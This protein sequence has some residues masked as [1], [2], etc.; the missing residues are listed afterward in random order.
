MSEKDPAY[1]TLLAPAQ[2]EYREKG[3]RFIGVAIPVA[4][5]EGIRLALEQIREDHHKARHVAYAW[6]LGFTGDAFRCNDDQEPS[7]SAG[8]PILGQI[9]SADLTQ[10]LVAVVRYFGGIKLGLS[11]L[12]HAYKAGAAVALEAAQ[13]VVKTLLD[14]YTLHISLERMG[15]AEH[16]LKSRGA[17]VLSREYG[18]DQLMLRVLLPRGEAEEILRELKTRDYRMLYFADAASEDGAYA[19]LKT[20]REN[21]NPAG[22]S[23]DWPV[24]N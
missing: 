16:L 4:N 22:C 20:V 8:R 12:T 19:S 10:V 3:S 21:L 23:S 24:S 17:E 13:I 15:E 7:G 1:R 5:E 14:G 18:Q 11:G 9:D 6:R 2:G